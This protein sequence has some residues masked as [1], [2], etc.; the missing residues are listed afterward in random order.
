MSTVVTTRIE[1]TPGLC[2]DVTDDAGAVRIEFHVQAGQPATARARL[3]EDVLA[4]PSVQQGR[5]LHVSLPLGEAEILA[6]LQ[7]HCPSMRV[8]A[9]GSTCLVDVDVERA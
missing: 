4:N 2:A 6:Y 3:A 5:E 8:R 9:A 7:V 1:S